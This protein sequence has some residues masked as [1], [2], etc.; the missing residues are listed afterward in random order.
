MPEKNSFDGLGVFLGVG[1]AKVVS[2]V[3]RYEM[4]GPKSL[5]PLK[6]RT[7]VR[8]IMMT[9]ARRPKILFSLPFNTAAAPPLN[10]EPRGARVQNILADA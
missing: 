2:W 9:P 5:L 3:R 1:E 4:G 6:N 7:K 10:N 8:I